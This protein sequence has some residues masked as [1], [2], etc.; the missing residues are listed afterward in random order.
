MPAADSAAFNWLLAVN[1]S[2][3][4]KTKNSLY[5]QYERVNYAPN[6]ESK[7]KAT[8]KPPARALSLQLVKLPRPDMTAHRKRANN[9]TANAG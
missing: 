7:A 8:E 9:E 5:V 6:A 4:T 1:F 3:R 2:F